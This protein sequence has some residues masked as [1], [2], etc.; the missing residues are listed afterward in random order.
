M[1]SFLKGN[2][3]YEGKPTV[4]EAC[5]LASIVKYM[6]SDKCKRVF[7][8]NGAGISTSSGIPDFRS[9]D[10]G[11][12]ANLA[13]LNLPYPEAVFEINFFRRNPKPFYMLAK[14]L[15]PGN[16]RPTPAHS[17]IKVLDNHKKLVKCFTQNIDTL[18]RRAGVPDDKLVEAHGSYA[19][20]RCIDCKR[21]YDAQKL[22]DKLYKEEVARCEKCGGLVKPDIVFFGESLPPL[23]HRSI[24]LLQSADLLIV[25]GTSLV[26][27]PFASLVDLVPE[28]C[29][30][31]LINLE[32]V[33]DFGSR[34]NDVVYLGKC[35][36]GV[37]EL[38]RLLGW[39]K[40]LEREWEKTKYTLERLQEDVAKTEV[41]EKEA[42]EKVSQ[43]RTDAEKEEAQKE[44]KAAELEEKKTKEEE[45]RIRKL[46]SEEEELPR[47]VD[48]LA[49][50]I[51]ESL[52]VSDKGDVKPEVTTGSEP[53]AEEEKDG[54]EDL[55]G[56]EGKL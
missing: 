33:G 17:F 3:R 55:K 34:P 47:E 32:H 28:D 49:K 24:P 44:L 50:E 42:E 29:P 25:M 54:T 52:A 10:T 6:K 35:D 53:E 27:H 7:I 15:Y 12:Y 19:S 5:D 23:F 41:K 14:E 22:K 36:D 20:Q 21:P 16:F 2:Q 31:L 48:E 1:F 26:V 37:R 9:P 11:L 56:P 40:E 39:D 8:M 46:R 51:G 38:C 18:E 45:A 13:R 43:A 4:L 30:R